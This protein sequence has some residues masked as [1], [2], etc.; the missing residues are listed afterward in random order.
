MRTMRL[1]LRTLLAYLDDLL[2]PADAESIGKKV[3]D[4]DFASQL[5]S[6][7]R[8]VTRRLRLGAPKVNGRGLALDANTVA[9]Y[10]DNTLA[11]ER[12]PE[13]ERICLESDM[14]LAEVAASHQILTLVL[15]APAEVLPESRQRMYQITGDTVPPSATAAEEAMAAEQAS[16]DVAPEESLAAV[17]VEADRTNRHKPEVPEYLRERTSKSSRALPIVAALVLVALLSWVIYQAVGPLGLTTVASNDAAPQA[18]FVDDEATDPVAPTPAVVEPAAVDATAGDAASAEL[19]P[20]PPA[21]VLAA[22]EPPAEIMETETEI[23][24]APSPADTALTPVSPDELMP[25]DA[26]PRAPSEVPDAL[27]PV[28]SLPTIDAAVEGA[29]RGEDPLATTPLTE[30]EMLEERAPQE[31]APANSLP[32]GQ[33]GIG[34]RVASNRDVLLRRHPQSR[35]WGQLS[36]ADI[37]FSGDELLTLPAYRSTLTLGVGANVQMIGPTC[38]QLGLDEATRMPGI[39]IKYGRVIL[40][41]AGRADMKLML[42]VGDRQATLEFGPA[43]TTV[44]IEVRSHLQL[45][46]DP[47]AAPAALEADFYVTSGELTWRDASGVEARL[48][49]PAREVLLGQASLAAEA[50]AEFPAWTTGI[51]DERPIDQ[52]AAMTLRDNIQA[53]RDIVLNLKEL[54]AD[55]RPEVA[56]LAARSLS[57]LDE[58]GTLVGTLNDSTQRSFWPPNIA[59]LR[60][61]LGRGPETAALVRAIFEKQR[62]DDGTQLYRLLCGYTTEQLQGGAAREL[63]ELLDHEDLDF[64]VLGITNLTEIT[65]SANFY[66]PERSASERQSQVQKWR[67]RLA[68]GDIVPK[69]P[70]APAGS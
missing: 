19:S 5:V 22:P 49:A 60:D 37:L 33:N 55:R 32:A 68:A 6:R 47:S 4:S 67:Q 20:A 39:A 34:R 18:A 9:E 54:A 61:G 1:T 30:E 8:D 38:I 29:P 43:E 24:A 21:R 52:R 58:F 7:V 10:L 66:R 51:D 44:A 63:V 17:V 2:E 53:D 64:R 27:A 41:S 26:V 28:S 70:P 23:D 13:F 65:G 16:F 59:A 48:T 56:S 42:A 11:A 62:S 40:M 45:G 46:S 15:G 3:S 31:G 50:G 12:I 36:A 35:L 25:I 57:Y 14:H 69:A